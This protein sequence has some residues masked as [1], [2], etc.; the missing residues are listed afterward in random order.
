MSFWEECAQEARNN[1]APSTTSGKHKSSHKKKSASREEVSKQAL[2]YWVLK[3][4]LAI[5]IA[6]LV[7]YTVEYSTWYRKIL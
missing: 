5:A 1:P 2:Y 3:N 6:I 7:M 4:C